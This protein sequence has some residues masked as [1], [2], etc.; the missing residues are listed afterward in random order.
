MQ[1]GS[2]PVNPANDNEG[3]RRYDHL[4][5]YSITQTYPFHHEINGICHIILQVF[6]GEVQHNLSL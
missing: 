4:S 3:A 5:V 6:T 2:Y 1:A